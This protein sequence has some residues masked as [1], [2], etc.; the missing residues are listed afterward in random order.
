MILKKR[1]AKVRKR[2]ERKREEMPKVFLNKAPLKPS[3]EDPDREYPEYTVNVGIINVRN[4]F[5]NVS[6]T[7]TRTLKKNAG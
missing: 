5:Y 6:T 7:T 4:F 3:E 1:F 2:K